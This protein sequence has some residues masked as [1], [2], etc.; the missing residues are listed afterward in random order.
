MKYSKIEV[1]QTWYGH[2]R[3]SMQYRG[4][5]LSA[6][7]TNSMAIDDYNSDED[8]KDGRILRKKRGYEYLKAEILRKNNY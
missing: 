1:K 8:E 3:V 2:W 5:Q 6:I 7:T 4:K